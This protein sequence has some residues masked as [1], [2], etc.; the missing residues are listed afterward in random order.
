[1]RCGPLLA[2]LVTVPLAGCFTPPTEPWSDSCA[3]T[4]K[5]DEA[6]YEAVAR[7]HFEAYCTLCHGSTSE[8]RHG[9]PTF[10]NYDLY[11]GATLIN[12]LTWQRSVDGTMPPM[13]RMPSNAQLL[14][15]KEFL[16]CNAV[17][18]EQQGDDDDSAR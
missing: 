9:S 3:D 11:A 2:A 18:Q 13:G 6:A 4:S 12:E 7:P 5:G 16:E 14:A 1:M 15:L 17:L 10:L 8:D